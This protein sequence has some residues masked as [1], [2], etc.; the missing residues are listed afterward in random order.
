MLSLKIPCVS[1]LRTDFS[2][3]LELMITE[4]KVLLMEM[5]F[6]GSVLMII[7]VTYLAWKPISRDLSPWLHSQQYISP[8]DQAQKPASLVNLVPKLSQDVCLG[9]GSGGTLRT[10][11]YPFYLFSV[12]GWEVYSELDCSLPG[13]S[14]HGIFQARILEWVAISFSRESSRPRDQT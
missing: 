3:G 10:F 6:L 7:F 11:R 1:C 5:L 8:R 9:K 13:S 2:L 14:I 12:T 4:H